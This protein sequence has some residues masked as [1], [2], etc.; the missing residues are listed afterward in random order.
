MIS[1]LTIKVLSD[2]TAEPFFLSEWGLSILIEADENRILLDT[3]S[4]G[5]FA[6]NAAKMDIDLSDVQLSRGALR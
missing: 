4:S 3:G 2:N 5:I 6:D 1:H